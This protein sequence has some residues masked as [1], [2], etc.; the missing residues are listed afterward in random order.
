[1]ILGIICPT[2][3]ECLYKDS[4]WE[5]RPRAG[6]LTFSIDPLRMTPS[7]LFSGPPNQSIWMFTWSLIREWSERVFWHADDVITQMVYCVALDC[8]L[9]PTEPLHQPREWDLFYASSSRYFS[10]DTTGAPLEKKDFLNSE[11]SLLCKVLRQWRWFLSSQTCASKFCSPA[12]ANFLRNLLVFV[13]HSN[14]IEFFVTEIG[15]YA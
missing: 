9:S 2:I 5:C 15:F 14:G 11:R 4:N 13:E 10:W 12:F 1:M 3:P 8:L 7:S 6:M